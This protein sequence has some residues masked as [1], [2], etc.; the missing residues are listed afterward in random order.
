MKKMRVIGV[1]QTTVKWEHKFSV[2]TR[3]FHLIE[4]DLTVHIFLISLLHY[5][6]KSTISPETKT[7]TVLTIHY[8]CTCNGITNYIN[9]LFCL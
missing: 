1:H 8:H 5:I 7:A 2:P 6:S 3:H 4:E 9:G